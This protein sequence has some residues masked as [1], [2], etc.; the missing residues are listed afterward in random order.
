[1]TSTSPREKQINNNNNN[2]NKASKTMQPYIYTVWKVHCY[3]VLYTQ[4]LVSSIFFSL[5]QDNS[6]II[7]NKNKTWINI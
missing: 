7:K 5:W 4:L 6:E 1:M 3:Q 2:N